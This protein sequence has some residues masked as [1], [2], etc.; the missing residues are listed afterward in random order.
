MGG[1]ATRLWW[2]A[3]IAAGRRSYTVCAYLATPTVRTVCCRARPV[4][5]LRVFWYTLLLFPPPEPKAA[6]VFRL[7]QQELSEGGGV[8]DAA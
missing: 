6:S 7:F 4:P 8:V 3:G 2:L 5:N 1:Y